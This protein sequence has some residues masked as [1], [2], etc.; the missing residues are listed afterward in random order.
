MSDS[1]IVVRGRKVIAPTLGWDSNLVAVRAE[2]IEVVCD[3]GR[4]YVDFASGTAV[5]NIG[6]RHPKVVEAIHRQVDK[7]LHT[8]GNFR[9][10]PVVELG[11][12]LAAICPGEIG[13]FFF[14][15]SGAEAVEGCLKLARYV[16]GRPAIIAFAGAF[17][18]RTLGA[19]SVT[20]SAAKYRHHYKPLLPEVYHVPYPNPYRM[21]DGDPARAAA[22]CLDHL[23]ELFTHFV[24]PDEIAAVLVEP[25]QGEGG[26]V[27]PPSAFLRELRRITDDAG[28]LLIFDEVQTGIGRTCKWFAAEH[29]GVVP[30]AMAV[31]KS[32]ASGLPLSAVA[33]TPAIMERWTK[34]AH[35]TTFGGN[36]VAC[37]AA[38]ATI[39]VI[40]DEGLL[41]AGTEKSIHV[42]TRLDAIAARHPTIGEVRGLGLMIGIELV[43]DGRKPDPDALAHVLA[44]WREAGFVLIGCGTH[45]NVVRYIPPL[46]A[47]L[48]VVDRSLDIFDEALTA[49]ERR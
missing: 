35:G 20:S 37:A 31:A 18:G 32:I 42:R 5:L 24:K 1:P 28:I 6:H 23:D 19:A 11:E 29:H 45:G 15:N 10:E 22:I 34:G 4:T 44:A 27:V 2:G 12:R 3:D 47:P 13:M 38:C 49:Y 36:P 8:G 48:D 7:L 9:Y 14:S 17:H 39:D 41:E 40:R 21:S 33:S 26:Y 46:I 43:K 30:D 16:T 25:L